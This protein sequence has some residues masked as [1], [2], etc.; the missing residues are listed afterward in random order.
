MAALPPLS[1]RLA[2]EMTEREA[3]IASRLAHDFA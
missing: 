2:A 3:A 1:P